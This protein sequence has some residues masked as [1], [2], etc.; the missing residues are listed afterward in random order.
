MLCTLHGLPI[1]GAVTGAKAD[2]R[3]VLLG[4]LDDPDLAD[5]IA[6]TTLIADKNYYGHEF[7]PPSLQPVSNSSDLHARAKRPARVDNSSNHYGKMSNQCSTPT[8]ANS[9]WNSTADEHQ[10]AY[11]PGSGNAS[12]A[13]RRG[14]AQRQHRRTHQALADR[15]RPLTPW[16]Q[17]SSCAT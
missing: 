6:G 13:H 8:K 11:S 15:L 4:M 16:N 2:E 5:Q 9:T 12:G 14:L 3:H 7:E 17:S 10:P 1:A